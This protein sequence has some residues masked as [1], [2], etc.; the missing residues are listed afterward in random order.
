[1]NEK[2]AKT[3]MKAVFRV[4][5]VSSLKVLSIRTLKTNCVIHELKRDASGLSHVQNC[6]PR[7]VHKIH[8]NAPRP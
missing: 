6:E 4:P 5:S 2:M 8:H 3:P 1:M 7:A